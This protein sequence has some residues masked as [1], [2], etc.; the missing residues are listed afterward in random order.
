MGS[1]TPGTLCGPGRQAGLEGIL[2]AIVNIFPIISSG[3]GDMQ[4]HI[5]RDED[6][7]SCDS[8]VT[9]LASSFLAA[10]I[11]LSLC[12]QGHTSFLVVTRKLH[13]KVNASETKF[14]IFSLLLDSQLLSCP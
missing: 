12:G 4:G 3:P 9:H 2:W 10:S 1:G 8:P 7:F 6:D 5:S 14:L 13:P 11:L